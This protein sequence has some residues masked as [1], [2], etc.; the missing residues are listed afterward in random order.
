[1]HQ[2]LKDELT[3][4]QVS[5]KELPMDIPIPKQSK[6]NF[7]NFSLDP[8]WI[9][10]V[11]EVGAVNRELEVRLGSRVNG[12]KIIERGPDT[13]AIVDVLQIWIEKYSGNIILE[14]WV[15]DIL[16][17]AQGL[18]LVS[19]KAVSTIYFILKH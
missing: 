6:Y 2:R 13:E 8:D 18:I 17:A 16:Q 12:L 10:D 7:S 5:L 4:L 3:E 14:K 15:H 11:G 9:T 1:M 19:G